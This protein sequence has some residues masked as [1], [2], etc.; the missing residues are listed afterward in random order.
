[1]HLSLLKIRLGVRGR[2]KPPPAVT[3]EYPGHHMAFLERPY[4]MKLESLIILQ[5]LNVTALAERQQRSLQPEKVV[6][7]A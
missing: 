1:M 3:C 6:I 7:V 5:L 2:R 4:D